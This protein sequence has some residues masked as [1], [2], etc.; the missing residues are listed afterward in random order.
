VCV[1]VK[2]GFS[3]ELKLNLSE[4]GLVGGWAY[5]VHPKEKAQQRTDHKKDKEQEEEKGKLA[6]LF[7]R[8]FVC[9]FARQT[10]QPNKQTLG[11]TFAYLCQEATY[12][13]G[14]R[15]NPKF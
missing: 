3:E 7:D 9:L 6:V 10:K 2:T 12:L 11:K 14:F 4:R 15:L 8:K 13:A 5:V 1:I